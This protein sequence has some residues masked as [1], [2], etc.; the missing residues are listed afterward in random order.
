MSK[1]TLKALKKNRKKY[2][3]GGIPTPVAPTPVAPAVIPED[4][5]LLQPQI[6]ETPE[7]AA[8]V[9]QKTMPMQSTGQVDLSAGSATRPEGYE[10]EGS[11]YT[12]PVDTTQYSN[13]TQAELDAFN[14]A[15]TE[16]APD[17]RYLAYV[18]APLSNDMPVEQ[19]LEKMQYTSENEG[20]EALMAL[21]D[22]L[23]N[24]PTLHNAKYGLNPGAQGY[25]E[26]T[27]A[28]EPTLETTS[29]APVWEGTTDAD[30]I[31]NA[32]ILFMK[33][34]LEPSPA[35]LARY[36]YNGNGRITSA[37]FIALLKGDTPG[38]LA[39]T[40]EITPEEPAV[41]AAYDGSTAMPDRPTVSDFEKRIE[42]LNAGPGGLS[43]S[44]AFANSIKNS[45]PELY[46]ATFPEE[47]PEQA[48]T[49]YDGS[50]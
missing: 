18:N 26:P 44:N 23:V 2:N 50:T 22:D 41:P 16:Q 28:P 14:Q 48:G 33:D 7:S 5:S 13:P 11:N 27:P 25:I 9:A 4:T 31:G 42:Y 43:A 30:E 37:D 6:Q 17:A 40:Q 21:E 8:G 12:P 34:G 39:P 35:D 1:K 36:D 47:E 24:Y 49:D 46:Y 38:L 45:N 20:I 29:E 15:P 32:A 19:L 3:E 10:G